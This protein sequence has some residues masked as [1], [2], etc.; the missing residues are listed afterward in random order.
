MP[1]RTLF[2]RGARFWVDGRLMST[3]KYV[4]KFGF[5]A[6]VMYVEAECAQGNADRLL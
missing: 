6:C 2:W 5:P 3:Y 1:A 4:W